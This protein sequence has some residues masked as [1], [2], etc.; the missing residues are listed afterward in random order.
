M[1]NKIHHL[2]GLLIAEHVTI[3]MEQ[4]KTLNINVQLAAVTVK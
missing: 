3:V 4:E 2:E 1:L